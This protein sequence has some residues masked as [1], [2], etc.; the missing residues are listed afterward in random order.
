M[1]FPS[2]TRLR[3]RTHSTLFRT[4]H[5]PQARG[6]GTK[7]RYSFMI[8]LF[9]MLGAVD[10]ASFNSVSAAWDL[11]SFLKNGTTLAK[12]ILGLVITLVGVVCVGWGIIQALIKFISDNSRKNWLMIG[13]AILFGAAA[14][15]GGATILV[16]IANS[17][18]TTVE[19]L[20]R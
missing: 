19:Q 3:V 18:N 13:G 12:S 2:A 14:F 5:F 10:V 9:S 7:G 1:L 20:G 16:D 11:E 4:A 8:D 17:A 15:V 6:R